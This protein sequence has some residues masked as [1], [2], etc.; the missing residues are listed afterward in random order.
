MLRAGPPGAPYHVDVSRP[1]V[2]SIAGSDSSG[3]S[4][5]Q[6]DIATL[7]SLGVHATTVV[8]VV[9]AQNTQGVQG[10]HTVPPGFVQQQLESLLSDLVP[11][12][13]KTGMLWDLAIVQLV[14]DAAPRLGRLVVDPVMV[15]SAGTVMVDSAAVNA[16]RA[17]CACADVVTP[18][19]L[20]AG[21][22]IGLGE[23]L[24][25]VA[26]IEENA[27][28]LAQLGAGLVVVTGGRGQ[29]PEVTDV[30][31]TSAGLRCLRSSRLGAQPI[32]G[33]GCTFSAAI[34]AYLALESEPAAAVDSA[35][36]FVQEQLRVGILQSGAGLPGI[37]HAR[38]S[39]SR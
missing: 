18:N 32:R 20:E 8:T 4:G 6:A 26:A 30:V 36:S 29:G 34:A 9:T 19:R 16:Y 17:L 39:A 21:L 5:L 12:A 13:T 28:A 11:V 27:D 10:L 15:N 37:A 33:T 24:D 31:V 3:S 22:L 14:T 35:H 38:G 7:G 2:L 1:V 25:S 23:Q